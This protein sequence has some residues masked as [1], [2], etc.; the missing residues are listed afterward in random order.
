MTA[1]AWL[2]FL[3]YCAKVFPVENILLFFKKGDFRM[4]ADGFLKQHSHEPHTCSKCGKPLEPNVDGKRPTLDG[5]A[6]C[7]DCFHDE[8][9]SFLEKNPMGHPGCRGPGAQTNLD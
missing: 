9:G 8:A 4:S 2:A 5:K 6:V 7:M 1:R 3:Y